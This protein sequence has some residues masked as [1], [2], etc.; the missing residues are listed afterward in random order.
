MKALSK[1]NKFKLI[2]LTAVIVVVVSIAIASIHI[3]D[4]SKIGS[5]GN[6]NKTSVILNEETDTV[7]ASSDESTIYIEID[8][9]EE[10]HRERESEMRDL[11]NS[12]GY[13]K[14][15]IVSEIDSETIAPGNPLE[16]NI[17]IDKG[18]YDIVIKGALMRG[19]DNVSVY[20]SAGVI[21]GKPTRFFYDEEYRISNVAPGKYRIVANVFK[22]YENPTCLLKIYIELIKPELDLPSLTAKSQVNVKNHHDID[23]IFNNNGINTTIA[24]KKSSVVNLTEGENNIVYYLRDGDNTS[25]EITTLITVDTLPPVIK[26]QNTFEEYD[27]D[28]GRV[29][30]NV[31][32][33][34]YPKYVKVNG[35]EKFVSGNPT[36]DG[37]FTFSYVEIIGVS[38]IVVE[39]CDM[40]GNV[41]KTKLERK[42]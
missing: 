7:P 34:E 26:L 4:E 37:Y 31:R 18:G 16:T 8:N 40:A 30:F 28:E 2:A 35:I 5:S 6:D 29:I 33:N 11:I 12:E 42:N 9:S 14:A 38:S 20:N 23:M 17:T 15:E 19:V 24:A 3:P 39:A 22:G 13:I 27:G 32:I 41:A 10:G 1:K 25:Q 36:P 21:V